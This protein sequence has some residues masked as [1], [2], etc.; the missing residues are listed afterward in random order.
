M[1]ILVSIGAC[2]AF[3]LSAALVLPQGYRALTLRLAADDPV[4]LADVRLA[5]TLDAARAATEIDAALA[6]GDI[7]LAH[8]FV[9]LADSRGL[10]VAPGQRARVL[11]GAAEHQRLLRQWERFGRGFLTGQTDDLAGLSGAFTGDLVGYGDLR[12]LAREG[13][14]WARGEEAD[15]LMLGLAGV[16]LAATGAMVAASWGAAPVRTGMT[17]L[18]AAARS[19]KIGPRLARSLGS[20]V[21]AGKL[22][23]LTA[24]TVDIGRTQVR[25][26]ARA[27][28]EGLAV[29][30]DL[31]DVA[32]FR[33]LAEAEGASTLAILKTLGRGA[34]A[35]G[36][37]AVT[38]AL[39]VGGAAVNLMLLAVALVSALAA[40][41]RVLWPSR[42]ALRPL[43]GEP[44]RG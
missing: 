8:S 10:P 19:G 17:L 27:A 32:K 12:D 36:A 14:R 30:D 22:G 28:V 9:A 13:M 35:L 15:G 37:A 24:A 11:S 39:W 44:A 43:A 3:L 31:A 7:E 42:Q 6:A 2:A 5:E 20:A 26:G 18:K 34:I 38:A 1:R 25:A 21:S 33:R 29:S 23:Q 16:G 41:V 40:L 4:K